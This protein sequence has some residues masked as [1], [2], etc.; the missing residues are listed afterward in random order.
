MDGPATGS[1]GAIRMART[2]TWSVRDRGDGRFVP[3]GSLR[4]MGPKRGRSSCRCSGIPCSTTTAEN[5][6]VPADGEYTLRVRIDPPAFMRHDELN[7][8]RFVDPGRGGV[9]PGSRRAR[10]GLTRKR[11]NVEGLK[12]GAPSTGRPRH[13]LSASPSRAAHLPGNQPPRGADALSAGIHSPAA[14]ARQVEATRPRMALEAA[15]DEAECGERNRHV[16]GT[17]RSP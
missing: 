14:P 10:K 4:P 5:V 11:R 3:A 17:S 13:E 6:T 15:K 12:A 1:T 9:R 8:K 7:G 2:F 16:P